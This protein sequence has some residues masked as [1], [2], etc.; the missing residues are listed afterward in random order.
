MT[1]DDREL[2]FYRAV[3]DLFATLRGVPHLMSPK[4]FQLLRS[5]WGDQ[6]PLAAVTAGVTEVFARRR[7]QG[8]EDPVTSLGYCRHAV[9]RHAKRM[10]EMGAGRTAAEGDPAAGDG[11]VRAELEA[12]GCRLEAAARAQSDARPRVEDAIASVRKQLDAAAELAPSDAGEF[13]FSLES[14]LLQMCFEALD[15]CE[16]TSLEERAR[17]LSGEGSEETIRRRVLALRDRELRALLELPR[18][19]LK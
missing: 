18:L 11:M 12:L 15:E 3:E 4:D 16:R 10:A 13:L 6:V 17:K 8:D 7:E 5:W 19:E 1:V 9:R 2:A 14:S